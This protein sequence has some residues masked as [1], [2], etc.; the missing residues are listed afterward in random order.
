MNIVHI[1]LANYY[2][3]GMGYQ[4][5]LLT[6]FHAKNN[7]VTILTSDFSFDN[8]GQT[9]RK[10]KKF[11]QNEYDIPVIVLD[12][13][14]RFGPYSKYRDYDKLYKTLAELNPDVIFCH[15]GQFV[16]LM[17]IVRYCK[18]HSNVKL[19]I[20]QHGDYYNSPVKSLRQKI[21][22]KWIYG[23]WIRKAIPYTEKFWGVTPWRC[24]YLHEIYGVP[25]EKIGL[26]VMGGDDDKIHF[27]NQIKIRREI[28]N[29]YNISESDFLI[30]T[31]GK[32]DKTKN[33]HFVIKAIKEMNIP[34]I[35][36]LVFGQPSNDFEEE[37][38]SEING[39]NQICYIGW[40]QSDT[41]YNYYLSS[42]LCIFPGTHS[43][44]WEQACSCG[45]PGIFK[46]WE[47]MNHVD[48]NGSALFLQND[49]VDE[50]KEKLSFI[51]NNPKQ[52]EI[53]KNAAQRGKVVFSYREIAKRALDGVV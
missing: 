40:I 28:R 24:Q 17:D 11:Y 3:D 45:L 46:A 19:Y 43:V 8:R 27:D 26:L 1:C 49:S 38:L 51:I 39:N 35:K 23:Y 32:I 20:D 29:K 33:I 36:L 52:F 34:N 48:L 22:H 5:N 6:K 25:K 4:E 37:F 53:M 16:A 18:K 13:S 41:V 2:V 12:K 7:K 44:L 42:D 15:G 10:V 30:I 14:R 9:I 50:I 31:G 47:G 21:G